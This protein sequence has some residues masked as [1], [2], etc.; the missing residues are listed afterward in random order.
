MSSIQQWESPEDT[1]PDTKVNETFIAVGVACFA[2]RQRGHS[3]LVIA[4]GGGTYDVNTVADGTVTCT[5]NTT[6]YIVVNR[7]TRAVSTSTATTNWNDTTTYGRM[8][9]A[10]FASGV[11][12]YY[13]ER[14]S[15]GGIFDHGATAA[16]TVTSV[17]AS[18][19]VQTVSGSA[20][21]ATGTIRAAEV[22]NAQ[23][24]T[25]YTI[26]TG[27]RG[28]LLTLSN[29]S[30]I[31]VT[32]PQAGGTFPDG[33]FTDVKCLGA[34][35][36][37]ITPTTSTI[38]GAA[39]VALTTNQ[40]C[41]IVSDGTNY[42]T[43]HL[44]AAGSIVATDAIWDA[45]GD[46]AVGS[47]ANTAVR[48]ARG[49]ALQVLRVNAGGT[50]LEYAA[51]SGGGD[52][53]PAFE[54]TSETGSTADSDPGA[55]MFKWNNATQASATFLYFDDVT[56]D[57]SA[58]DLST[59]FASL[60]STGFIH[61]INAANEAQF[62][63][64]KWSAV[65]DGTGYWK[66]AVTLQTSVTLADAVTC[67]VIFIPL[68]STG[69]GTKTLGI[70]TPMTSQPYA[71]NYATLDTRNSIAVLEFDA[72]VD[73]NIFWVW[74]VPEGASLGSGLIIRLHWMAESATSGTCRWGV[75]IER[76]NTDLD[77]NSFD[78]V[79]TAGGTANGTSGISTTT[80]I[81]ITTIDSVAAGEPLRLSVF[82]DA[83]GTS[84]TDDMTG[85]AQLFA[86]EIRSA[87]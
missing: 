59:F 1:A 10:V 32:L 66:F 51:P 56:A 33:W 64:W 72:S 28:K 65:T 83:D 16:G 58:S 76:M 22:F 37:T 39:S 52:A 60:G 13:D 42:R 15:P 27:D 24:G 23:T 53:Y 69:S 85:D 70:L 47:G 34:G 7:S 54:Y 18:G 71:A 36:A 21:T 29:G 12:T 2:Q 8:A 48:L 38:D 86:V 84:G 5:D 81:T 41:R 20:I 31:A 19:G 44:P 68:G 11:P 77:V 80:A 79:A 43:L 14:F 35:T 9:R 55:G 26:L 46:L 50:D 78:T 75:E 40:D 57:S 62:Q 25:T 17:D 3:G 6:N 30:S 67:K 73:E 4:Y 45:A 74:V 82:R 87:A 61:I 63:V 49:T